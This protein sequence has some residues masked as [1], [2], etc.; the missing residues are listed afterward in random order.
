[1]IT[2]L[3]HWLASMLSCGTGMRDIRPHDER[4]LEV[5]DGDDAALGSRWRD[6][7]RGGAAVG[8][9]VALGGLSVQV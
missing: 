7:R 3:Y 9:G 6:L 2:K 1:M 4:I 5:G 8:N